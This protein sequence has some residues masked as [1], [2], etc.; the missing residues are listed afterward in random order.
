MLVEVGSHECSSARIEVCIGMECSVED[1]HLRAYHA[2]NIS[3]T[4]D[5]VDKECGEVAGCQMLDG[6]KLFL[7]IVDIVLDG[8]KLS[9]ATCF[10]SVLFTELCDTCIL[11][12][13]HIAQ[14][15]QRK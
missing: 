2:R 8:Y 6:S 12:A 3:S 9:S 11:K 14:G 15:L 5:G 13:K 4:K 10:G 1:T 7:H